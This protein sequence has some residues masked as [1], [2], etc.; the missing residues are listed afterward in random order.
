MARTGDKEMK[1]DER[2][3]FFAFKSEVNKT[4]HEDFYGDKKHRRPGCTCWTLVI[5]LLVLLITAV[6]LFVLAT[7]SPNT[8]SW[9]TAGATRSLVNTA[10][11]SGTLK[12][13][14]A[15]NTSSTDQ[16][17]TL[18]LTERELASQILKNY[19]G[20]SVMIKPEGVYV[21]SQLYGFDCYIELTPRID[22]IKLALDVKSMR[23]GSLKVPQA[24]GLPISASINSALNSFNKDL[25][26]V[27]LQAVEL[28]PGAM[29]LTGKV[30]GR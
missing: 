14:L 16:T 21:Q 28:Q 17:Q 7:R 11:E 26:K 4:R 6:V 29:I 20:S 1:A 23:L 13:Q 3:D 25:S 22:G 8:L 30:V 18:V 24:V 9:P 2:D 12:S 19:P 10:Q 27:E 5:L 15:Q